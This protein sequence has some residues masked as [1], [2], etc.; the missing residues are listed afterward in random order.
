MAGRAGQGEPL[1]ADAHFAQD[2]E[3]ARIALHAVLEML[4]G[5]L[6]ALR[7]PQGLARLDPGIGAKGGDGRLVGQ[8]QQIADAAGLASELDALLPGIV[9]LP[10]LARIADSERF[11]VGLLEI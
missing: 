1:Q 2:S 3:I 7:S 5:E 9:L 8:D 6:M 10:E 4:Q 11:P